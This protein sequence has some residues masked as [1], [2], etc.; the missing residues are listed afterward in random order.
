MSGSEAC[1]NR[2]QQEELLRCS[3]A[4]RSLPGWPAEVGKAAYLHLERVIKD[5]PQRFHLH[6]LSTS[7]QH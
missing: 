4:L 6:M 3:A 1:S 7:A 5:L 2:A